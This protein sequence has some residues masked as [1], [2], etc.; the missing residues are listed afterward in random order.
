MSLF[1]VKHQH[2]A[3][4]CPAGDPQIGPMLSQH[5]SSTNA[6]QNGLNLHGEAVIDGGH[7]LYLIVEAPQKETVDRFM[8]PFSQMG[9]VEVL[10][11]SSCEA[12]VSRAHC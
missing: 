9:S 2:P 4:V 6:A 3:E 5:V 10:A 7:T 12:V 1:V 11:A 8:A